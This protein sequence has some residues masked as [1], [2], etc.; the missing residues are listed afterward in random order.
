M[1]LQQPDAGF[2]TAAGAGRVVPESE[3]SEPATEELVVAQKEGAIYVTLLDGA[4]EQKNL[5]LS[6]TA[7]N[8][9]STWREQNGLSEAVHMTHDRIES[10]RHEEQSGDTVCYMAEKYV[11][12][13]FGDKPGLYRRDGGC[14]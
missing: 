5:L 2:G 10:N 8:V 3:V 12:W 11:D 4:M 14:V 9:F 6:C 1:A 13:A 7:E